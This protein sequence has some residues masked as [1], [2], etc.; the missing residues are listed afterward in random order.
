MNSARQDTREQRPEIEREL[1]DSGVIGDVERPLGL[2]ERVLNNETFQ[3]FVILVVL[4]AIWEAY[5]R[6]LNNA[7]LF[8]SFTETLRRPEHNS[9]SAPSKTV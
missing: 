5:A 6:W 1:V 4:I 3:R 7:L 8:P 9:Y 2:V